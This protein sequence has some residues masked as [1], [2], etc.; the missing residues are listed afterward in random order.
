MLLYNPVV[1]GTKRW[2]GDILTEPLSLIART[3]VDASGASFQIRKERV[4][5]FVSLLILKIDNHRLVRSAAVDGETYG[6]V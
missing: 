3:V 5:G 4:C 2:I 1:R 6:D